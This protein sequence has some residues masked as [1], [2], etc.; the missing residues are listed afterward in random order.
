M[1]GDV[2]VAGAGGKMGL[3]LCLMLRE[4]LP[5]TSRV[6][7]V[8]RFAQ[9]V[10][11]RPF[12][13]AGVEVISC[14]LLQREAVDS[15]PP[16]PS[17]FYLAGQKFGTASAPE[18]TWMMNTIVPALV[19]ERYRSSRIVAFST[20]CV[21]PFVSPSSGG[22]RETDALG[23]VGD[24]ANS[25][26][27]RERIFSHFSKAHDTR[28]ALYRLNYSVEPRYGV[29]VDIGTKI[30]ADE[31]IDTSMGHV[32]LIWQRDAVA[33]AIQSMDLA[34]APATAINV[35]GSESLSVREVA[36]RLG[37]LLDREP[38]FTGTEADTAWLSNAGKSVELWG[39]PETSV[40][41]MLEWVS[42]WLIDGQPIWSK[43]TR[44]ESRAGEY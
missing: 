18:L 6:Y 34:T 38:R 15:L 20:G 8:S 44:F 36:I 32:N 13:E 40:A 33:R 10:S 30:L 21:Y 29:P 11:T 35:R 17:I 5:C 9:T 1:S 12:Q 31:P 14:D 22:S 27:G 41:Q 26:V 3:H 7:A 43:P 24:Y 28:V 37:K 23:P 16:C 2:M 19:A 25:C 42:A 39:E 4:A